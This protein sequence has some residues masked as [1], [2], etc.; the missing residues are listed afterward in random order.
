[1]EQEA[2]KSPIINLKDGLSIDEAK[3]SALI[4]CTILDFIFIIYCFIANGDIT[5]N[6]L[7]LFQTLIAAV[8]GVNIAEKVTTI[9]RS[10]GR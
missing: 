6:H 10:K 4:L 1:M 5:D 3:V 2:E 7:F 9:I 8:A